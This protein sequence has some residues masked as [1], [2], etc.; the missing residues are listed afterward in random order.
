MQRFICYCKAKK[1]VIIAV[2]FGILLGTVIGFMIAPVKK[3][4]NIGCNN[5]NYYGK[6]NEESEDDFNEDL[7]M[8]MGELR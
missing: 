7:A 2:S 5:G 3:G 6:K 1:E 8:E 4:F